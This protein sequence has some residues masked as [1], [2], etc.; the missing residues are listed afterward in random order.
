V[1]G[2][3]GAGEFFE[4]SQVCVQA[5]GMFAEFVAFFADDIEAVLGSFDF[6][7]EALGVGSHFG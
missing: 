7:L 4:C 5:G 3:R 6:G 1:A 2:W